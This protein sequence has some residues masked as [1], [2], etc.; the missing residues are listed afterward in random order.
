M[1][2]LRALWVVIFV[3][4]L[5]PLAVAQSFTRVRPHTP[6]KTAGE[7]GNPGK[8]AQKR[9][10]KVTPPKDGVGSGARIP[11]PD[12]PVRPGGGER[13]PSSAGVPPPS[14]ASAPRSAI[15][16]SRHTVT[17]SVVDGIA[18][19]EI[20]QVFK[21][22][23]KVQMEGTYVCPLP[24]GA[25]LNGFSIWMAGRQ[26][27]GSV[28]ERGQ[29]RRIY[30]RIVGRRRD[31]VLVELVGNGTA[32]RTSIFPIPAGGEMRVL[33]EYACRL[34]GARVPVPFPTPAGPKSR[35]ISEV[36]VD[37]QV[38]S[39]WPVRLTTPIPRFRTRTKDD[40]CF[41]SGR[42]K[43]A[44]YRNRG[45]FDVSMSPRRD[46]P[47]LV[48]NVHLGP[49]GERTFVAI[50]G[51]GKRKLS[52]ARLKF[53]GAKV[54]SMFPEA[55]P[56]VAPGG[57]TLVFGTIEGTGRP[58]VTLDARQGFSPVRIETPVAR[59]STTAETTR[60][61]PCFWALGKVN[62][63]LASGR[64][65]AADKQRVVALS[66]RYGILTKYTAFLAK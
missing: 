18:V 61:I 62:S 3:L 29:A 44:D 63:I 48:V 39:S 10:Q 25:A 27:R 49:K 19:T 58:V 57:Q 26:V 21:N 11:P 2:M 43:A 33:T 53:E 50:I 56:V 52:F 37:L 1:K 38:R 66:V 65:D 30:D 7:A 51:A 46:E 36:E 28:M 13:D 55:I 16:L 20:D 12:D 15:W 14:T 60:H 31:P 4:S 40:G 45:S 17:I 42:Y 5:T 23:A 35:P 59:M 6:K 22:D 8:F 41:W 64:L 47:G 9:G 32:I 34:E 24:P 54:T